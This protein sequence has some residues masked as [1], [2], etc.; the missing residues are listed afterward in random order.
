MKTI[1]TYFVKNIPILFYVQPIYTKNSNSLNTL[2]Q[3]QQLRHNSNNNTESNSPKLQ[4]NS[5]NIRIHSQLS[6]QISG[7]M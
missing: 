2:I 4:Q 5:T 6:F 1:P 3:T 7:D